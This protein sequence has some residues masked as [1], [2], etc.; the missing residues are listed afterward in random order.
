MISDSCSCVQANGR[1]GEQVCDCSLTDL[2]LGTMP[3]PL[4]VLGRVV[5]GVIAK[6]IVQWAYEN[7]RF[8]FNL[9]QITRFLDS[10]IYHVGLTPGDCKLHKVFTGTNL[11][12]GEMSRVLSLKPRLLALANMQVAKN[13]TLQLHLEGNLDHSCGFS[14]LYQCIQEIKDTLKRWRARGAQWYKETVI[15]SFYKYF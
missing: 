12:D 10:N 15:Y 5:G 9:R 3:V 13:L 6:E 11:A 8:E 4:C 2:N 1:F 7:L 14:V